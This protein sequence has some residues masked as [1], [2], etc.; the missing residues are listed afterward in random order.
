MV[1]EPDRADKR[2]GWDLYGWRHG[3]RGCYLQRGSVVVAVAVGVP[4][5]LASCIPFHTTNA[6]PLIFATIIQLVFPV[7]ATQFAFSTKQGPAKKEEKEAK[8]QKS[9]KKKT[10]KR[11]KKLK[12]QA[13]IVSTSII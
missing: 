8:G 1:G 12:K 11:S 6:T 5:G 2:A 3:Q 4:R 10:G 13:K 7:R 9:L